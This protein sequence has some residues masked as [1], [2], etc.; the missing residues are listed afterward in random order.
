MSQEISNSLKV[1]HIMEDQLAEM[2][3]HVNIRV[4]WK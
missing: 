3:Y 2:E 4:Q 1:Y